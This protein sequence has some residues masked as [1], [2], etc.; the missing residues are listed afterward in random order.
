MNAQNALFATLA[1][2]RGAVAQGTNLGIVSGGTGGSV[3]EVRSIVAAAYVDWDRNGIYTNESAYLISARGNSSLTA[4]EQMLT[5]GRGQV[6]SCQIVLDNKTRRFSPAN[7]SG[8]LYSYI[9]GG[10]AYMLPVLVDVT[11]DGN[12]KT[13]FT[14]YIREL[15]ESAPTPTQ[16]G[17]VTLECRAK[18]EKLLQ[19]KLS[20]PLADFLADSAAA[21]TE[22]FH[23]I[24]LLEAAGMVDGTDFV[25]PAYALAN[26]V[27]PTIDGGI[28]P[29]RYVWLDDESVLDEIWQLTAACCGWFYC[30]HLGKFHYHNLT[31]VLPDALERQYGSLTTLALDEEQ[32]VGLQLKWPTAE[33]YNEMSV[34]VSPRAPGEAGE[35]WTPDD[36]IVVQPDQTKVVWCRLDASQT[37]APTLTFQGYTAGGIPLNTNIVVERTNYAQRVRL[38]IWNNNTQAAYL[39]TLR[40]DG[41]T[42]TGGRTLEA[43]KV[44]AESFWTNRPTRRRSIRNNIYIQ[45]EAQAETIAAYA[46]KRQ[47]LP[48]LMATIPG[49][50]NPDLR[51][52]YP[53]SI[54]YSNVVPTAD[55]ITGI[56]SG[57]S[58]RLDNT[59]FRQ[60]VTV[61]ETASLFADY[62]PIFVLGTN[63]LGAAGA[64]TAYLFY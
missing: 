36:P 46:L 47:E 20:T 27:L 31:A 60:D 57:L 24:N 64:D 25:S 53:V 43:E 62:D 6:A 63:K 7:S 32:V 28:F 8:A 13:L 34:E 44:S 38:S 51:L 37:I 50:D 2:S 49:V 56:V 39:N 4:P 23:I 54:E 19:D 1:A 15:S 30:D 26:S 40:L 59:G 5:G 29:I 21:H 18:D 10:A 9:A 55:K 14:G 61:L 41:Q 11:I 16:T 58:W 33:L 42:L 48:V 12:T 45:S 3:S 17:R 52:A 35:I 22:D